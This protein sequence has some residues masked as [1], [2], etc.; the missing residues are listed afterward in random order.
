L[1]E[2][3]NQSSRK[4]RRDRVSKEAIGFGEPDVE[5]MMKKNDGKGLIR[6]LQYKK[7]WEVRW[8][9][10]MTLG[11]IREPEAVESLIQGL[12]DEHGWVRWGAVWAL[13]EIGDSRAIG[14]LTEVL[15]DTNLDVQ[16]EAHRVLDRL[17]IS[18]PARRQR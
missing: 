8:A 15:N 13:G 14:P 18:S 7:D 3:R 12:D 11:E 1:K 6:A 2:R 4:G 17:T 16:E 10:A 5:V 9:A